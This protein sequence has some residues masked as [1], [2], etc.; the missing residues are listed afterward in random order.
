MGPTG[1]AIA[2]PTPAAVKKRLVMDMVVPGGLL[3]DRD[4]SACAALNLHAMFQGVSRGTC[5]GT[6]TGTRRHPQRA[7][8]SIA[9]ADAASKRAMP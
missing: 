6:R 1:A 7:S 8:P 3:F 2:R 5:T 9:R 4:M